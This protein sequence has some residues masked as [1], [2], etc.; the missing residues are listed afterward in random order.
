MKGKTKERWE[1]LCEQAANE[2]DPAIQS[3]LVILYITFRSK[4]KCAYWP[5]SK[6]F[7]GDEI[8][9]RATGQVLYAPLA[10]S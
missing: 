9:T 7:P 1:E 3:A 8:A 6:H 4:A 10:G 2:Q 5:E